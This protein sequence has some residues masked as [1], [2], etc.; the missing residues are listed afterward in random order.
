MSKENYKT[1]AVIHNGYARV[2][3]NFKI[4]PDNYIQVNDNDPAPIEEE[5]MIKFLNA[6]T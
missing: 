4:L 1:F 5:V 3:T 6:L 2:Y